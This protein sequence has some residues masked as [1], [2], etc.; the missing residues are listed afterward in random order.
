MQT[1]IL[2]LGGGPGG[3]AAAFRAADLGMEVTIVEQEGKLGGV[4]LQRGCIPSKALLHVAKVL[5]EA[6]ELAEWGV[7]FDPPKIDIDK[8][9]ARKEKVISTLTGGLGQVAKKRNVRIV[10]ARGTFE[11]STR[12]KLDGEGL[13]SNCITFEKCILAAG[14]RPAMP[15]A[16]ALETDRLMDSTDSLNLADVPEKLLVIGGGYIG[17]EM[18][19]VYS[20]LGSAVT[21]VEMMPS[22]LPGADADLVRPLAKRLKGLFKDIYLNTKVAELKDAGDGIEV[23]FEGKDSDATETFDRVLVSIGRRPNSDRLGLENTDV[24][25]NDRGFVE[26]DEKRRTADAHIWA[27][28]DITGDP[29]LAHKAS[30]EGKVAAEAIAGEPA[31]YEPRGI[32]AV[33]FTDPEIAWVGLSETEA[34]KQG[35]EIQVASFPWAASGRAQALGRTDGLT[36]VLVDPSSQVVLGVGMVGV[37]A[38]EL[39]AESALALEMGCELLDI[40]ETIH[41]HPTMSETTMAAAEVALGLATEIYKPLKK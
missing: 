19:T 29:M 32:P 17:L 24:V 1:Q 2:V 8:V 4:C 34:E 40:A 7:E 28:G 39:I 35:I 21:V 23:K 30:H 37:G 38:G 6:E 31:V 18:G 16:F 20:Q 14:S 15:K 27:I 26:V 25:V 13:E 5:A 22:L 11:S 12:L 10:Q 9:R 33:V 41:P 36:K 3:Y